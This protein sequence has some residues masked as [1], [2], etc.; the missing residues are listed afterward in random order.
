MNSRRIKHVSLLLAGP[1]LIAAVSAWVYLQGGR[2]VSTDNAYVKANIV[3]VSSEL[4]GR[5]MQALVSDNQRIQKDQLLYVLDDRPYRLALTR[6]EAQLAEARSAV[7]SLQQEYHHGELA[8]T[9]ASARVDYLAKELERVRSL[10]ARASVSESQLDQLAFEWES[11]SNTRLEK[12]QALEVIKARLGD[13]SRAVDE[14]PQVQQALAQVES[15][16]LDLSHVEVRAPM[17]GVAVNVSALGGENIVA[18]AALLSLVD[19]QHL[20]LEANFKETD[21]THLQPGQAVSVRVDTFPDQVWQAHVASIT[22]ATG[23]QFSLLPAQNSSGNWV[24]VVQRIAVRID[25][26]DYSGVPMLAAGMSADVEVD[27]GQKRS[28][29]LIGSL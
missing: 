6:A 19:D 23:A 18:G 22:P 1:L 14:H 5:V 26:D 20:W 13:P 11:A 15:A 8:V 25:L 12:L 17:D 27:I 24:K 10:H 9:N 28:L 3:S 7:A 4:S 21:L 29:S 2:T 16:R